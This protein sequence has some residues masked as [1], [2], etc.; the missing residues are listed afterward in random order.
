MTCFILVNVI[1]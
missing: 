1:S